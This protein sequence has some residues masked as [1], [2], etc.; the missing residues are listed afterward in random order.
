MRR[1][2]TLLCV[3]AAVSGVV[4]CAGPGK[5][6]EK[7]EGKLAEG[8]MWEAWE[9]ATRALEKA[10]ANERAKNAA[11]AAAAT[12]TQDWQR[13]IR[14]LAASDS[15]AAA[16]EAMKF[17][18]FRLDAIPYTTIRMSDDWMD[19]EWALRHVAAK[20][21]YADGLATARA[22]RPKKAYGHFRDAVRFVPGYRD[23][24][25]RAEDALEEAQTSVAI[26]PL[27][28]GAGDEGIGREV[29]S[30]WSAELAENLPTEDFFTRV[31]PADDVE[32]HLRVADMGRTTR[33]QA[34]RLAAKAGA[35][36]VVW[37]SIGPIA[38]RTGIHFYRRPVWHR[39]TT[40][41]EQGRTITR[42]VE[43]PVEIVARTRSMR[44]DLAYEV[45]STKAGATLTRE[46]GPRTLE[47]RAVWTAYLPDG[48]PDS[49]S[50]VS[51]EL[52]NTHPER[53]RQIETE[54]RTAMGASTTLAQVIE[55]KRASVRRPVDRAAA[56]ARCASGAAF[57][58]L[59][60]LPSAQE[61]AQASLVAS[62]G[63]VRRSLVDLDDVDDVD[64]RS[65]SANSADD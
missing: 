46:S 10:P 64:L 58:L 45:I 11:A 13:R 17:V 61:L 24:V 14:A 50:L 55:A 27:R 48:D 26:V 33:A 6:A 52:R 7:S 54:W 37:G 3:L 12:I 57:V 28:T 62:W 40:K 35:D 19:A 38:S 60:D 53:A 34:I 51:E 8:D 41:D 42:W 16:E 30:A 18:Q 36:R 29:A 44:V 43:V 1:V 21:H 39:E 15:I 4:G 25:A 22:H 65:I 23:A 9:L 49:Y 32:R 31:M 56:V 47:A 2:L 20:A 59:E 5:L 63:S